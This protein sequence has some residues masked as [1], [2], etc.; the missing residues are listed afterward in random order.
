MNTAARGQEII[1][2]QVRHV[3]DALIT[4]FST[5]IDMEDFA[6]RSEPERMTAFLSRALAAK[7]VRRLTGCLSEAGAASVID[8]RDDYGIDAVAFTNGAPE[9]WLVQAKWSDNYRAGFNT[10]AANK[11]VR[12]FRQMDEQAFGRFN[13]RF[14]ALAD[15]VK[16]IL[17]DPR[18]K[19]ILVIAVMGPGELSAEVLEI[20]QDAHRDYNILGR[21]LEHRILNGQDFHQAIRDDIAPEPIALKATMVKGWHAIDTPYEAYYGL[22]AASE[23]A[24][25]HTEHHDRLYRS[26]L[27]TSLGRTGV[28]DE[29]VKSFIGNPQNF[30]YFHNGI[31]VLCNSVSRR[32]LG[33]RAIGEPVVLELEDASVVNGAQTVTS[34]HAALEQNADAVA[35]AYVS[36]RIISVKDGPEGFARDITTNTNTQNAIE[37]RDYVAID[38]VQL[39]IREDFR[40]SL[41]KDYVL[42]RGELEPSPEAGCSVVEAATALACAHPNPVLSVRAKRST[43]LLWEREDRG[44]YELLFGRRPGADQIWRSVQLLRQVRDELAS[45]RRSLT[46]RAAAI[47]DN[48]DLLLAHLTFQLVGTEGI[49]EPD[50]GWERALSGVPAMTDMLLT[51]LVPAIDDAFGASSYITATFSSDQRS[52]D[53]A[54]KI[55]REVRGGEQGSGIAALRPEAPTRPPRRPNSV[56][57]LVDSERIA[58]GVQLTFTPG[59]DVEETALRGWLAEDPLRSAATWVNN[60][61]KP[62]LWA[63][64]GQRYSPT[65]LVTHIWELAEWREAWVSVQGP[66][67]WAVPGEG[68]LVELAER[69]WNDMQEDGAAGKE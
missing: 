11:L 25:W 17:A 69:I 21:G 39:A 57:L 32:F 22:V 66:K 63:A 61:A 41:D 2:R 40:L 52:R 1:S 8:G 54:V 50:S 53:L 27:R 35:D 60:R 30:W 43:N 64:D 31:T 16:E 26:N 28:N 19:V 47:A 36:V 3:R 67:Q 55:L 58:D 9:L 56:A 37:R 44:T 14:Q 51:L 6:G 24:D 13:Q 12:G 68:T 29:L 20:M 5:L 49:D 34:A 23:L 4:E 38:P 45:V 33:K 42:K 46:P 48:G 62:L 7:A 18:C 59:S 65:G 15:G 10:E